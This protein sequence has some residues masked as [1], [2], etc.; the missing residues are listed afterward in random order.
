MVRDLVTVWAACHVAAAG[1]DGGSQLT[2]LAAL[3]GVGAAVAGI[4]EQLV[5]QLA[6]VGEDPL[7]HRQQMGGV[8]GLVADPH[9]HDHLVGSIDRHLAVV[10][11]NPT[12]STWGLSGAVLGQRRDRRRL[13]TDPGMTPPAPLR[14]QDPSTQRRA[15]GR[16]VRPWAG[17]QPSLPRP[18]AHA[19]R[20]RQRGAPL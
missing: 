19:L 5:R 4:R 3:D 13:R 17:L 16:S 6:G 15:V 10:A 2:L 1:G 7:Q 9:R 14:P 12:T 18:G 20:P 8:T 11:L